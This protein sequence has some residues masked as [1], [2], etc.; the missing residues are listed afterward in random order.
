MEETWASTDEDAVSC[1]LRSEIW[2]RKAVGGGFTTQGTIVAR[3]LGEHGKGRERLN[4][5]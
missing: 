1:R 4:A 2:N 5:R 3:T